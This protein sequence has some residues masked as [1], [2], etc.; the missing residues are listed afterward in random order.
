[1]ETVR[2]VQGTLWLSRDQF[3]G[4]IKHFFRTVIDELESKI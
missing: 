1:M 2:F 4:G 3:H